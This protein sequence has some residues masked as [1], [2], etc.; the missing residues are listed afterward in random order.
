MRIFVFFFFIFS[1]QI[2]LGQSTD[3]D[4]VVL[5]V[6]SLLQ[7]SNQYSKNRQIDSALAVLDQAWGL[8]LSKLGETHPLHLQTLLI[9]GKN[10]LKQYHIHIGDSLITKAFLLTEKHLGTDNEHDANALSEMGFAKE[11][12]GDYGLQRAFKIAG[13]KSLAFQKKLRVC[14]KFSTN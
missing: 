2:L 10:H 3:T 7:Q 8:S 5:Q 6:D 12:Q 14:L 9:L 11:M 1:F 13:A 4:P